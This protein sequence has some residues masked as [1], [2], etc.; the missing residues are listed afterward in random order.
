MSTV[1]KNAGMA[2]TLVLISTGVFVLYD[3]FTRAQGVG[4]TSLVTGATLCCGSLLLLY[5]LGRREEK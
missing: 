1:F 2:V 5:A 4:P 3:G